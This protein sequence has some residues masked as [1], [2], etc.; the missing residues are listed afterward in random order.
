MHSLV[1]GLQYLHNVGVAHRDIKLE[2]IMLEFRGEFVTPKY[3]DFG[4]S[5]VL[6]RT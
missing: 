6:L 3:I 1:R 4:L 5:K 2:N